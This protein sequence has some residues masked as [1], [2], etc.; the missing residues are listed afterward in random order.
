MTLSSSFDS[1]PAPGFVAAPPRDAV[2]RFEAAITSFPAALLIGT[3]LFLLLQWPG[4]VSVWTTGGFGDTDDAMRLVEVREFLA[5]K[6]WADF[7]QTRMNAPE[8]FRIH[9]SRVVDLPLAGL[10]LAFS[11][12]AA[13]AQAELMARLVFPI[14]LFVATLGALAAAA[15]RL[16]GPGGAFAIALI[17][18]VTVFTGQFRAGRID[19]HAPQIML[20]CLC[21]L[22]MLVSLDPRRARVAAAAALAAALSLAISI[23]NLPFLAAIAGVYA[24]AGAAIPA[25]ARAAAWFGGS[26]AAATGLAWL[27]FADHAAGPVCDAFSTFHLSLAALGGVGLCALGAAAPRLSAPARWAALAAL[28]AGLAAVARGGFPHCLADPLAAVPQIMVDLWLG[29]V[30]EAMPL[31]SEVGRRPDVV[32]AL[33]GPLLLAL[34]ATLWAGWRAQGVARLRWLALAG[35]LAAGVA[36]TL[37]QVR[38]GSAASALA[39]LAGVGVPVAVARAL[40]RV[41]TPFARLVPFAAALPFVA[42]VW[43]ALAPAPQD[44]VTDAQRAAQSACLAPTALAALD[45][46]AP[47]GRLL[48]SIDP[49]GHLLAFTRHELL[50]GAYHRNVAGDVDALLAWTSELEAARALMARRGVG[51]AAACDGLLDLARYAQAAPQGLAARLLRGDAPDW[52]ERVPTEGPWRL[53][54]LRDALA[55]LR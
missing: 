53:Y 4:L 10:I 35:P 40:A 21:V 50:A 26:F 37:W 9:W 18:P 29:D 44:G 45:R 14:L 33:G 41:E 42:M 24:L 15:R 31:L 3:A 19:H 11:Q 22:A 2:A 43:V 54:R 13:T 30:P 25:Q 7:V 51:L 39:I 47:P 49:G 28:G 36:A 55:P 8:G 38:A 46:A 34:P 20:L 17:A 6:G 1:S 12:V 52:L 27:I 32:A 23:E 5:G 48:A 16:A